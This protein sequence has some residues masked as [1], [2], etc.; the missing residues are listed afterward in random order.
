MQGRASQMQSNW[1]YDPNSPEALQY[2]IN[3]MPRSAWSPAALAM[4]QS[5]NQARQSSYNTAHPQ[6]QQNMWGYG[7]QG[8]GL[9]NLMN[10]RGGLRQSVAGRVGGGY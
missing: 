4:H 10:D 3:R 9:A 1:N 6:E 2:M 7:N 8:G 5:Q